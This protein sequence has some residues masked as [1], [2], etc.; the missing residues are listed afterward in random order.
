M[1][2][3]ETYCLWQA[4]PVADPAPRL[5]P[6][7]QG[8]LPSEQAGPDLSLLITGL[9]RVVACGTTTGGAAPV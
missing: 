4:L 3:S 7:P 6:H 1:K 2:P 8:H 9:S 5:L